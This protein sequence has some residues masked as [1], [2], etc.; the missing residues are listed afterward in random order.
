MST[1]RSGARSP[2][3]AQRARDLAV[4]SSILL[5]RPVMDPGVTEDER[6]TVLDH[7]AKGAHTAITLSTDDLDGLF[8][9][10]A[11]AGADVVQ[12]PLGQEYGMRD[13]AFRDPA[14]HLIRI[15]QL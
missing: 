1:P 2:D 4:Q 10:V 8:E 15:N 11:G 5:H 6:Q 7:I 13:C 14:G 3:P 9:R 12:E